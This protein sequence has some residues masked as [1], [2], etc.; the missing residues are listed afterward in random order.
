MNDDDEILEL[1][2]DFDLT[3]ISPEDLVDS[4]GISDCTIEYLL[5]LLKR[6]AFTAKLGLQGFDS[7]DMKEYHGIGKRYAP[8]AYAIYQRLLDKGEEPRIS[9]Y[10]AVNRFRST[11]CSPDTA[12]FWADP[13]AIRG[14]YESLEKDGY[15]EKAFH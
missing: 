3:N 10:L 4:L 15:Y 2:L 5:E 8:I 7:L 11:E 9:A 13:D 6:G 14:L 12:I 1:D